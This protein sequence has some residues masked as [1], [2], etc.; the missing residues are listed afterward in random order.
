MIK[1]TKLSSVKT[2]LLGNLE[3]IEFR[4]RLHITQKLKILVN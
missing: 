4:L 2:H 1:L 3:K